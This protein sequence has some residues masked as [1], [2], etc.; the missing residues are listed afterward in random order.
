[1]SHTSRSLAI[2]ILISSDSQKLPV[3]T[4]QAD[5]LTRYPLNDPRDRNLLNSLV[6][7]VLRQRGYLDWILKRFSKHPLS[8]MKIRTLQALRVG[9][10]QLYFHDRI[11]AS[12]AINETINALKVARQPKWLIGFANG[13]LRSAAREVGNA[14]FEQQTSLDSLPSE[15]RFNH[16]L[17]IYDRWK[18]RYGTEKANLIFQANNTPPP[19]ILRVNPVKITRDAYLSLLAEN[20]IGCQPCKESLDA[21]QITTIHPISNLPGY[22]SGFFTVQDQGAQLIPLLLGPLSVG[23]YIDGCAGVGGK[24]IS[25]VSQNLTGSQITAIEPQKSRAKLFQENMIRLGIENKVKLVTSSFEDF[26]G[27][28]KEKFHGIL[29]DV[30]CSGLGVIRRHPEIRWNQTYDDLLRY[31]KIQLRLLHAAAPLIAPSGVLVYA[32]CSTEPE[33]NEE[34]VRLFLKEHPDFSVCNCSD[35]LPESARQCVDDQG[36]F[37]PAPNMHNMDG[38]F[39]VRLIKKSFK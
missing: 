20:D 7:G 8:K 5:L 32:T 1:M 14:S 37:Y 24:T 28:T 16:P 9:L 3:D 29:L 23:N 35:V 33:E 39:A 21:I 38:F 30:P 19:L 10:F 25:I 17:W 34:P 15:A 18:S 13:V 22:D 4:I 27:S 36:F 11:P 26:A 6:N 2:E 12:A 31:Q